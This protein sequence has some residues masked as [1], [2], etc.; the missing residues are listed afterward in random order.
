MD[1]YTILDDPD[2]INANLET[3]RVIFSRYIAKTPE[4]ANANAETQHAIIEAAG[5]AEPAVEQ[6]SPEFSEVSEPVTTEQGP[7]KDAKAKE[8]TKAKEDKPLLQQFKELTPLE[9][10]GAAVGA[11]TG[12]GAGRVERSAARA[13]P[14][15]DPRSAGQK[16]KAKTGFGRGEGE[17]VQEVSEAYNRA[18]NKGKV[19]GRILPG[20]TLN[21]N[22][23][24]EQQKLAEELAA[25]SRLAEGAQ[26]VTKFLGKIPLGSTLMGAGAGLE[27]A[28]AYEALKKGDYPLAALHGLGALGSAATLIP[29]PMTRLGGGAL[30]L[31]TIP[32][33]EFYERMKKK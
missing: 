15:V 18:K 4:F 14:E 22:Q 27:S 33:I 5:L 10:L 32:A 25:K 3:K 23:W 6:S 19:S 21:I 24:M 12:V 16:W 20:E 26:K 29:T 9:Q 28:E 11:G 7:K 1:A 31:A 13:A 30:S 2:Y 17:T 8:D